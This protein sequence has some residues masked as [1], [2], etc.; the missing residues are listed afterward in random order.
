VEV[1][2]HDVKSANLSYQEIFEKPDDKLLE[3]LKKCKSPKM[4]CE[5]IFEEKPAMVYLF[6]R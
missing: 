6:K 4:I 3:I 5:R 1:Y 2:I